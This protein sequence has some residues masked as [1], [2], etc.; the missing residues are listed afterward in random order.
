MFSLSEKN[1]KRLSL[2]IEKS[3]FDR[4]GPVRLLRPRVPSTF[5]GFRK[6]KHPT[7][8]YDKGLPVVKSWQAADE[9]RFGNSAGA[10]PFVPRGSPATNTLNGAP[11]LKE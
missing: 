1:P 2:S 5:V 6:V 9:T 4:L 7:F 3:R 11:V 10:F 8:T